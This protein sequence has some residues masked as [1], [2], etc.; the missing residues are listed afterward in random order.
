MP[1]SLASG[2][3]NKKTLRDGRRFSG[4]ESR[5]AANERRASLFWVH[6]CG[7]VSGPVR[8]WR[9]NAFSADL[10]HGDMKEDSMHIHCNH[11]IKSAALAIA[12][13]AAAQPALAEEH[14]VTIGRHHF[15]YY[16]NHDIYY[17]PESNT[18]YWQ[19]NGTWQSG[20][21]LPPEDRAYIASGGVDI[22][23][24]TAIPYTRHEYVVQHYGNAGPA[25]Q[26][27]TTERTVVADGSTT[28]TTT[29]TKRQYIYYGD[30]DIFF[31]P[32]TKMYYWRADGT[33]HSGVALP[34]EDRGYV[35]NGGVR[36]EL[37]T[38]RPYTQHEYVIAHYRHHR[39]HDEEHHDDD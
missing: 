15:V 17:A 29:T 16:R 3:C 38:D 7:V 18:Y 22:E 5:N 20:P 31:A 37:D 26:T 14:G 19:T 4:H 36:I 21:M 12:I 34:A 39:D 32:D 6:R 25:T 2:R 9:V 27:T 1:R 10:A 30:H 35:R 11:L 24:D 13:A 33:W 28:T 8:R 23:L